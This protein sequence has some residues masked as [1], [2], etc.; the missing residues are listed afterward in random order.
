MVAMVALLHG[1]NV[2]GRGMLAMATLRDVVG[3]C[4][5]EGARTYVQS[6]NVVFRSSQRSASSVAK[7][8]EAALADA[9]ALRPAVMVRTRDQLA[10]VVERN[11]FLDR[12][13]DPKALHVVFLP[14][15]TRAS[16]GSLD[17]K[18]Y[19]PEDAQAIGH[20]LYLFCPNGVGRSKLTADLARQKGGPGTMRNWRT[21]TKLLE[22]AD[23]V[24]ASS[25]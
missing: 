24:A 2:G 15:G 7:R 8:L 22:L 5:Y 1:V 11:P 17:R 6:G 10:E 18:A 19:A 21:V 12:T 3:A 4:G 14:S 16:L 23:E 9:T 20:E 13:T 25:S